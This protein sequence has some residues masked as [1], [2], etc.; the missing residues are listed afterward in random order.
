M[1]QFL[2]LLI[3]IC[4]VGCVI[5]NVPTMTDVCPVEWDNTESVIF[6]NIDS[7]SLRDIAVVVQFNSQFKADTFSL[8]IKI[9][10]PDSVQFEEVI[11]MQKS[12]KHGSSLV[13]NEFVVPYRKDVLF[14][15]IGK[16]RVEFSPFIKI[17]GVEAVGVVVLPIKK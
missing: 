14:R 8:K 4:F 10:T 7:V 11:R 17:E 13:S 6:D 12:R 3:A 5:E 9:T 16:Y 15:H 1:R 2:S